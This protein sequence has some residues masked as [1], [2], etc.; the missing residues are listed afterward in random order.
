[1]ALSLRCGAKTC[2]GSHYRSPA[3]SGK[4]RCRMHGGAARSGAP[5]GNKNALKHGAYTREMLEQ[6]KEI[7]EL[8][9]EARETLRDI[10]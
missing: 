6:Q 7:M 1:M 2:K 3:V 5:K 8:I 9:R 4:K 10:S